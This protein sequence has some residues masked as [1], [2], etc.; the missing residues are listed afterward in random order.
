MNM[1]RVLYLSLHAANKKGD[2]NGEKATPNNQVN[3]FYC[4]PLGREIF[5]KK[6]LIQSLINSGKDLV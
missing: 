3:R 6:I 4:H 5:F 1:K 2:E